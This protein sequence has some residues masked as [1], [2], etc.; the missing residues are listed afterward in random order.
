MKH[1]QFGCIRKE[2]FKLFFTI[3]S[4][5]HEINLTAISLHFRLGIYMGP[6][7]ILNLLFQG[8]RNRDGK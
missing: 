7:R 4:I 3:K 1:L 6:K 5:N 8:K 2:A